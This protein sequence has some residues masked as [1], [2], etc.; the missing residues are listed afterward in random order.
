MIG[1]VVAAINLIGFSSALNLSYVL[2][3]VLALAVGFGFQ[4]IFQQ[5]D[6]RIGY[7]LLAVV[8][9]GVVYATF[10]NVFVDDTGFVIRYMNMA[11]EGCF[12]CYNLSDGPVFGISGFVYGV[13]TC[14]LAMVLPVANESI[15]IGLNFIGIVLLFYLIL[16]ILQIVFR[17]HFLSISAAALVVLSATRFLFSSTAGL[18]T[19]VHLSIVF[20]GVFFF[21]KDHRKWMWLLFGLSVVSKLDAVPLITTLSIIHLIEQR[22]D[23]FGANWLKHWRT[24]IA[25][26]GTPIIG[27][28]ILSFILFDGPLPQS[29]YAKLY[30]HSHPS[31]HW[32]PFLELMMDQGARR[33]L[34]GFALVL[35]LIHALVSWKMK[36]FRLRDLAFGWGFVATMGL[37]YSYNPVE[38]M[39]WY[40]AMPELLLFLQLTVSVGLL[41][42]LL[43]DD[44]M[45]QKAI[46]YSLLFAALSIAAAPMTMGEKHWMDRYKRTVEV[47]RLEI[48]RY[49]S[50]LPEGD[51]LVAAHG[52]FGAYFP[53][54]VLDLSGLNSKLA[55]DFQRNTDSILSTFH[56]RYFIHHASEGNANDALNN[57]YHPV[58]QW[59]AIEEYGY[60]KWVLYERAHPSPTDR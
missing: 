17:D 7:F 26:A 50:E 10:P 5:R 18:E 45:R 38:R 51:T 16:R 42:G 52:H 21:L 13:L 49:L 9:G 55:T 8:S 31:G 47:E 32:F 43:T 44:E 39:T 2:F 57:N 11:R 4:K 27:F 29:A 36:Q 59:T 46:G 1:T 33:A 14:G 23:Y 24:G 35:P 15:I 58:K 48:G 40:Y 12:Y 25:C 19:N 34:L 56:P 28:V 6:F 37:Y 53:G 20:A 22:A 60:P 41:V 3:V 30:H 54:Y